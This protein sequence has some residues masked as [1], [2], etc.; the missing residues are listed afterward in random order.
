MNEKE[1]ASS[2]IRELRGSAGNVGSAM[3]EQWLVDLL[4]CPVDQSAVSLNGS[5]L[6]CNRC[7]RRYP[8]RDG[9]PN[10]VSDLAK[11]EQ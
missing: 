7:G 4:A 11:S 9:I 2:G 5:E 10:M 6:I 8:V 1:Q 3:L